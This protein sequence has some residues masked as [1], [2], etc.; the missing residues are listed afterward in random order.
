MHFIINDYGIGEKVS[1]TTLF[2]SAPEFQKDIFIKHYQ[3]DMFPINTINPYAEYHSQGNGT[4]WILVIIHLTKSKITVTINDP[5]GQDREN[6]F[7]IMKQFLTD[8]GLLK[9]GVKYEMKLVDKPLQGYN[10]ECG[11]FVAEYAERFLMKRQITFSQ[12]DIQKIRQKLQKQ[13]IKL[14]NL[15]HLNIHLNLHLL[16]ILNQN[17]R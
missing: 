7:I 3:Y 11:L 12:K 8:Q 17:Q 16:H 4:H 15:L 10:N 1:R 5:T 13:F 6:Y 2:E 14:F 9:K